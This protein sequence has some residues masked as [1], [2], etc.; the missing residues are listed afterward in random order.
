M[1]KKQRKVTTKNRYKVKMQAY[2]TKEMYQSL[3]AMAKREG[4]IKIS[5]D[6]C[7]SDFLRYIVHMYIRG[8][9]I[10]IVNL[11]NDIQETLGRRRMINYQ[12]KRLAWIKKT[13]LK[14]TSH[15]NNPR[16]DESGNAENE[17]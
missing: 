4:F 6:G 10:R 3:V 13:D 7:A 15:Y 16:E 12:T 2:T 11:P 8:E 17:Q 14:A 9:L 1:E 5:G